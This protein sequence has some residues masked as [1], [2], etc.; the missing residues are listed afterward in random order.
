MPYLQV[1]KPEWPYGY[2]INTLLQVITIFIYGVFDD[3]VSS[4]DDTASSGR[5]IDERLIVKNQKGSGHGQM[6]VLYTVT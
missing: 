6:Q 3:A 5:M 2:L 1:H 4:S